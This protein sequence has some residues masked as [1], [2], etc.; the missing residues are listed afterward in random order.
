MLDLPEIQALLMKSE[1]RFVDFKGAQ[2]DLRSAHGVNGK[3]YLDMVKDI[4]CMANTPRQENAYIVVGVVCEPEKENQVI[5]I[6]KH[7]DDNDV[8]RILE[9]WLNP[10]PDVIYQEV[11][12]EGKNIGIY[13][14]PYLPL[15]GP[16][17]VKSELS[18]DKRMKIAEGEF[19]KQDELYFRRGTTNTRVRE[20]EKIHIRDWFNSQ[21][22]DQWQ[23]WGLLLA[24]CDDFTDDRH[25]VL[26]TSKISPLQ[27]QT[28]EPLSYIKWSVVI[29][30]DPDSDEEGL[31]QDFRSAGFE[32]NIISAV[33][34]ERT[35]FN[36]R[37]D[38]YW[39]YAQG[40]RGRRETLIK[41][42]E[43]LNWIRQYGSEIHQQFHHIAETILPSSVTIVIIWDDD[44]LN[45][46]LC[47]VIEATSVITNAKYVVISESSILRLDH[48]KE[49]FPLQQFSI[50]LSHLIAGL[51]VELSRQNDLD[52]RGVEFPGEFGNNMPVPSKNVPWL[53]S[54]LGLVHLGAGK[55]SSEGVLAEQMPEFHRGGV[56]TWQDLNL[57]RDLERDIT[58]KIARR[59]RGDL[60]TRTTEII[61]I[62]HKPGAGG[63]T[64]SRRILWDLHHEFPSVVIHSGEPVGAVD[65]IEYI[66]NNSR[67]AVLAL[68][69]SAEIADNEIENIYD[70]LRARNTGCVLLSVSR[71][72][73][74]PSSAGRRSFTLDS[75]LST[76]ELHRFNEKYASLVPNRRQELECIVNSDIVEE[77]TAFQFGLTAFEENYK[78]LKPYVSSRL[79]G[80]SD[81]QQQIV[82]FL[83]IASVYAQRSLSA[84]AFQYLLGLSNRDV[85]LHRVFQQQQSIFDIL[86]KEQ[87]SKNWRPIHDIVAR[88][89]LIQVLGRGEDAKRNWTQ[90]LSPWGKRFIEFCADG[91]LTANETTLELLR[92]IFILS[93]DPE[94][95]SSGITTFSRFI[96]DIPVREG[97]LEILRLLSEE[98][99]YEAHFW[100]HF[101][102]YQALIMRNFPA[103]LEAI[104]H[105]LKLEEEDPVLWHMKGMCYRYQA[106]SL[107]ESR[108][109]LQEIT[110]LAQKASDCF[111]TSRII[112]PDNE[113]AYISEIQLL[114]RVLNYATR[115]TNENIFS[116]MQ[117]NTTSPYVREA[118]DKAESLLTIVRSN[119]EGMGSS[120]WEAQ[121]RAG[122]SKIYGD[123]RAALQVWDSL[124]TRHDI[125][126]PPV[127]RQI[128]YALKDRDRGW[129]AMPKKSLERCIELLQENLDENPS[130]DRDLRQWLQAV[131][132]SALAPS[133]ESL[134]DKV[135]YW[136]ANTGALDAT[137]Y[138]Y[139]LYSLQV[140]DGLANEVGRTERFLRE[141]QE[142]S[143]NRR[144]RLISFEWLGNGEGIKKLVHQSALGEW[145]RELNFW[146]NS[147][148]L[149]REEGVIS[150]VRGPEG[151]TIQLR[152]LS[153]FFVPGAK[154]KEPIST[155]SVNRR[156]NFFLGFSYSGIRAW[157]VE[158][159]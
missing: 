55:T 102:R 38:T 156:V 85:V 51:S 91:W 4:L 42:N 120:T 159:S 67:L 18:R 128:V 74:L 150:H 88:E 47:T 45:K 48:I 7:Y 54:Q 93:E 52:Q 36:P 33:K 124:L 50:P 72:H 155:D 65:R 14:V 80:L 66:A 64:I 69:D 28:L 40:L 82:I 68:V 79:K 97:R 103:S 23:E 39:F 63:T 13:E 133:V 114:T 26:I 59:V 46:H 34:N 35:T 140:L 115:G 71:R 44:S 78:G 57:G 43:W 89:V 108:E 121:C 86:I 126:R 98:F 142:I 25:F 117:R 56:I 90:L 3:G 139:V 32:R 146:S 58:R 27:E 20:V 137:Y 107:M 2:Y 109:D 12:V 87:D 104:D 83:S 81:V 132:Y 37:H 158:F 21:R 53:K 5:G 123:Y 30:F 15:K 95:V 141:C 9:S 113:H 75:K 127:R 94:K 144:N 119:R 151:G 24:A 1:S 135:S 153:C 147:S 122:I 152:G 76:S 10:I 154:R 77:Q 99:P 70:R 8:Q 100:A 31:M 125:F 112:N 92:R 111:E 62:F 157:G 61:K 22:S 145:D 138:L 134:I 143:R 110:D 148:L 60:E 96:Q 11:V 16:Y 73:Q 116:F 29:D 129:S 41:S 49:D 101:G 118:F 136:K 19:L 149:K 106:Q 84:Q 105:A 131:R 6:T 130:N 17:Y